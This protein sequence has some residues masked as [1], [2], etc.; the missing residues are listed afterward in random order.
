MT[1]SRLCSMRRKLRGMM[2]YGM[3]AAGDELAISNDHEGIIEITERDLLQGAGSLVPGASFA[4]TF[5]LDDT[6]IEIENKMF[7][8]RPDCF[9][10]RR[11]RE[12]AGICGQ[13]F[14]SPDWYNAIQ[15]FATCWRRLAA[16]SV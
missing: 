14:T 2:S 15:E 11:A 12:I 5:G 1:L 9:G 4:K 16:R 3:L 6:I 10:Q 8:H 7:T 13:K